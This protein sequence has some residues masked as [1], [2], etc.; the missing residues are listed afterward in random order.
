SYAVNDPPISKELWD[1]LP[2]AT[3]AAI[4]KM[5]ELYEEDIALLEA[6][7]AELQAIVSSLQGE[8]GAPGTV[9]R[10]D[11]GPALRGGIVGALLGAGGFAVINRLS[12]S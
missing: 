3:K 5:L 10:S 11:Y 7:V 1:Q 8:F 9:S 12:A 6:E 2:A 4:V